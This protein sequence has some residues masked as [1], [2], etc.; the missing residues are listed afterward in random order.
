MPRLRGLDI[1]T[2]TVFYSRD[3]HNTPETTGK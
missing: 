1:T 2:E 3:E